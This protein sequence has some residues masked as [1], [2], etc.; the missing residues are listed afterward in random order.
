MHENQWKPS[1]FCRSF[2]CARDLFLESWEKKRKRNNLKSSFFNEIL[3]G[4]G[5]GPLDS[6][7]LPP[8][9]DITNDK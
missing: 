2:M 9:N 4:R 3:G 6:L 1:I 5:N 8:D 7:Q